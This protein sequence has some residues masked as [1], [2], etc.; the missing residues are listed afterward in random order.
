[1]VLGSR[2]KEPGPHIC[3]GT[4]WVHERGQECSKNVYGINSVPRSVESRVLSEGSGVGA[5][6]DGPGNLRWFLSRVGMVLRW[7][8]GGVWGLEAKLR[9]QGGV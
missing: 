1:V 9:P 3:H 2:Y 8:K 6:V 7:G 5:S 4:I